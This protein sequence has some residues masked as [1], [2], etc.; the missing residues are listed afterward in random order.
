MIVYC[1]HCIDEQTEALEDKV[2]RTVKVMWQVGS[3]PPPK[4]F[5]H[6]AALRY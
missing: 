5:S 3:I 4:L 2:N 6:P 1:V